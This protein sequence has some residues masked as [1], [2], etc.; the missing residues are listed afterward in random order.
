MHL[1]RPRQPGYPRGGP[2]VTAAVTRLDH[3]APR[4]GKEEESDMTRDHTAISTGA[5]AKGRTTGRNK[6]RTRGRSQG[7][8][9]ARNS[10][11]TGAQTGARLET[12]RSSSSNTRRRR[13]GR[14]VPID[15]GRWVAHRPAALRSVPGRPSGSSSRSSAKRAGCDSVCMPVRG[16]PA[17]SPVGP[18]QT[19][20]RSAGG[21][22]EGLA[23][24]L[25]VVVFGLGIAAL[26]ARDELRAPVSPIA[27]DVASAAY[28]PIETEPGLGSPMHGQSR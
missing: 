11:K 2:L 7:G 17:L 23:V 13:S 22:G 6:G 10:A 5:G 9:G 19:P 15:N 3:P 4:L 25:S 12:D 18:E 16:R 21:L 24:M 20:A 8:N 14:P 28:G 26:V 1:T 27:W